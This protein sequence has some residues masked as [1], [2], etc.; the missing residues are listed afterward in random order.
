MLA[1]DAYTRSHVRAGFAPD[2]TAPDRSVYGIG[3]EGNAMVSV[4]LS[5][6]PDR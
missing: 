1:T 4:S 5:D 2:A 6:R 3:T